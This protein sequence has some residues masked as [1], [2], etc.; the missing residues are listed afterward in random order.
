MHSKECFE[1]SAIDKNTT[2]FNYYYD[3]IL[4]DLDMPIMDGYDA[5]A[6]IKQQYELINRQRELNSN[7][8]TQNYSNVFSFEAPGRNEFIK[9][10]ALRFHIKDLKNS[11]QWILALIEVHKRYEEIK[12]LEY[13][14]DYMDQANIEYIQE[15]A[16]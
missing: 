10:K 5:C 1:E 6:Q 14:V 7:N 8:F 13:K 11:P 4:L 3:L 2:N 9:D 12:E 16:N 15:Q